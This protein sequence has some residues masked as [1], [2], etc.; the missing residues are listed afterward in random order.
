MWNRKIVVLLLLSATFFC[1]ESAGKKEMV[2]QDPYIVETLPGSKVA[3]G[4]MKL[5]N[6]MGKPARLIGAEAQV[7]E[8]VEIHF[9][10]ELDGVMKMEHL[11]AID[12]ADG[13][14]VIFQSGSYHIMFIEILKPL[15]PGMNVP[16]TLKFEEAPDLEVVF[17]V[18]KLVED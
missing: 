10:G 13:E 2:V 18:R 16:V 11:K 4:Y 3:A 6:Q 9:M 8:Y 7:S 15:Q 5:T 14:T 12:L 1:R 17:P